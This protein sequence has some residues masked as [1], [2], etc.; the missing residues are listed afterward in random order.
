V[1]YAAEPYAQ[2]VDDLLTALTG[3]TI[4]DE[5]LFLP[6]KKP[7]RLATTAPVIPAAVR[8]SGLAGSKYTR[9]RRGTD[10]DVKQDGP[11]G[12]IVWAE[13]AGNPAKDAVWP[14]AG[15]TFYVNYETQGSSPALTDRNPGSVTRML[16]ESFAREFATMSKQLEAVYRAA[17]LDTAS[18]RDLEQLAALVGVVRR[19]KL[20]ASGTVVFSR[21]TPAPADVFI[22]AGTKLSTA[23]APLAQFETT[24]DRT[25]QRGSLSVDAPVSATVPGAGGVVAANAIRVLNRPILGIDSVT[26][27]QPTRLGGADETDDLL[28]ARTRR[29]L[30]SAGKATTGSLLGALASLPGLREKDI[31]IAE[32]YLAHPGVVHLTVAFPEVSPKELED[33]RKRAVDAIENTRPLGIRI[34]HTIDAPRPLGANTPGPGDAGAGGEMLNTGGSATELFTRVNVDVVLTP[35]TLSVSADER[36]LLVKR[37]EDVVNAF[38]AEAGVGEVLVYNKLVA[39]LMKID[40]VLDVGVKLLPPN[41]PAAMTGRA[42]FAPKNPAAKPVKG[43][44]HVRVG[45][46]LVALD[47]TLRIKLLGAAAGLGDPTPALTDIEG[48]L[49]TFA[50]NASNIQLTVAALMQALPETPTYKVEALHYR[51]EYTEAGVRIHQQDVQLALT[52]FERLW[53]RSIVASNGGTP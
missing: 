33:L 11:R 26:N 34:E 1:T 44:V 13:T 47:V 42:N 35:A 37:G 18:G 50:A 48:K 32:D 39:E 2:F 19:R 21:T 16:A 27:P 7:F 29:A 38:L 43:D 3:G 49:K 22:V 45:G 30:E 41:A 15:S 14:D 25:L 28:R 46:A 8:V 12:L 23:D 6:E 52:G 5:F 40:G 9:F 24:E 4:R 36:A 53:F 20:S 17:F 10:F 31:G 51:A